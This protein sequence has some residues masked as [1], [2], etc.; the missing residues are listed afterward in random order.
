MRT[1]PRTLSTPLGFS[2][3]MGAKREERPAA[4]MMALRTLWGRSACMP[5]EVGAPSAMRPPS[6]SDLTAA[7][8]VPRARPVEEASDL[9]LAPGSSLSALR[10][11][12]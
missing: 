3:E 11:V 1:S 7:F 9:W 4:R 10:T 5:S 12:N 2:Y 6:C 8:T